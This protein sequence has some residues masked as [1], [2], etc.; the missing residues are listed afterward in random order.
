MPH[1]SPIND[2]LLT[3]SD[4]PSSILLTLSLQ[5]Y[6][7]LR[8]KAISQLISWLQYVNEIEAHI[9]PFTLSH[10]QPTQAWQLPALESLVGFDATDILGLGSALTDESSEDDNDNDDD[11]D[12]D[13]DIT[14]NGSESGRLV[15]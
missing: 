9:G 8:G 3:V 4:L 1:I 11:D 10:S 5:L 7:T 2:R 12:T 15:L 6:N 14:P 13:S